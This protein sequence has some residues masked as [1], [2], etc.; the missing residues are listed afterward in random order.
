MTTGIEGIVLSQPNS[1][2][3]RH[4]KRLSFA[5]IFALSL[6]SVLLGFFFPFFFFLTDAEDFG[7]ISPPSPSLTSLSSCDSFFFAV[8]PSL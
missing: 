3:C 4:Y 1:L 8:F 5:V 6:S 2:F 7:V